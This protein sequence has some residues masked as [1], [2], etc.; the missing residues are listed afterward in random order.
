[1]YT[2]RVELESP[3][4][5]A[6]YMIT[7]K[8]T[9]TDGEDFSAYKKVIYKQKH[10]DV[11]EF[12]VRYGNKAYDLLKE[13]PVFVYDENKA[14]QMKFTVRFEN[15]DLVE[16]VYIISERGSVRKSLKAEW[17]PASGTFVASGNFDK[18][19][20]DYVPGNLSVEYRM[21][22]GDYKVRD[23]IASGTDK[24]NVSF[25]ASIGDYVSADAQGKVNIVS[26][27]ESGIKDFT[28]YMDTAA[29]EWVNE[30]SVDAA[31]ASGNVYTMY[32]GMTAGGDIE[33]VIY[34]TVE[35]VVITFVMKANDGADIALLAEEIKALTAPWSQKLGISFDYSEL[36][37]AVMYSGNLKQ[38]E[39][40][41][42]HR[43]LERL[44]F[45]NQ[46]FTLVTCFA[47]N[48]GFAQLD[49][50]AL[51]YG[52]MYEAVADDLDF[53][54]GKHLLKMES[55]V[56]VYNVAWKID[57]SGCVIDGETGSPLE[58]VT[59]KAYWIE[60]DVN[61]RE[62]W[63]NKPDKSETGVLWD[64]SEWGQ[65]NP[66]TTDASGI[67]SWD[68][69]SGWWRVEFQKD[70]YQT[71]ST[72][73]MAVPPVQTDVNV[74]M[75]KAHSFGEWVV[76]K[77][78]TC[79]SAGEKYRKCI[80]CDVPETQQIKKLGHNYSDKYTVDKAANFKENGSKSR[81]CLRCSS[82]K[83]VTVIPEL[84]SVKLSASKYVYD[85]YTKKPSV[86]VTNADGGK[87]S[88]GNYTASYASGRKYPGRYK[89]TVTFRGD[90]EGTKSVYFTIVPKAPSG[91][92]ANLSAGSGGYDDIRFSWKASTKASG[93]LV[94]YKKSSASKYTYLTSTTKTYYVKKNLSDG[95]KYTFKVVPYYKSGSTE[96]Y[97]TAQ[98][99][100][101]GAYTLKKVA[102]P[103]V[104]GSGTKVKV[105][106]K[107]INGETGYQISKSTSRNKTGTLTTYKTTSG[108]YK[109]ISAAKGKKYYYKVRAY[110]VVNV[111][112][113]NGPW[114][115]VKTY[116]RK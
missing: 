24:M 85:G 25:A 31:D 6:E 55:K 62:F 38:E 107:N 4:D 29:E 11:T 82:K 58:G 2:A 112:K 34:D 19:N 9:G 54:A 45:T 20:K 81:H 71:V 76:T 86:T 1:M 35:E 49:S 102:A 97:S 8:T 63:N 66:L 84:E 30:Y 3:K 28:Q 110:K 75:K 40:E 78:A 26:Y 53:F 17:D 14:E 50:P 12:S 77:E 42:Y 100:T 68:V 51:L 91:A 95:V 90:Y 13:K 80:H 37:A 111:K 22:S 115:Y 5:C 105:K 113:I 23:L 60:E 108:T 93:Y 52:L 61:D 73:W 70:C 10:A 106:W 57:P 67:Y 39:A 27:S 83:D 94:Y 65:S 101:A 33:A 98:Y 56:P 96:Y 104:T 74:V 72:E 87:I 18:D 69:P 88:S 43:S 116:T 79:T 16:S 99:K 21:I 59:V 109:T 64:A 44:Y 36:K 92:S 7:A 41:L 114:S 48:E 103:A 47:S 32:Y 89:V 15:V 46:C